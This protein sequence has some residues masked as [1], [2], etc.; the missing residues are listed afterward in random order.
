METR[1]ELVAQGH[2]GMDRVAEVL[3]NSSPAAEEV[4]EQYDLRT[5]VL[6]HL[7][8]TDKNSDRDD[9]SSVR[10]R[11]SLDFL[12]GKS[13]LVDFLL[14]FIFSCLFEKYFF[15]RSGANQQHGWLSKGP[16]LAGLPRGS[17]G[18]GAGIGATGSVVVRPPRGRRSHP[19]R[20]SRRS[21]APSPPRRGTAEAGGE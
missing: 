2:G 3:D 4:E 11:D 13:N 10:S 12:G 21:S 5:R 9:A 16:P 1:Q 20:L 19:R 8:K 17:G 7:Q 6:V 15:R 18:A 14:L